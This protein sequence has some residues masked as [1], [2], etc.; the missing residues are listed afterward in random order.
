MKKIFILILMIMFVLFVVVCILK[1]KN[2]GVE[3]DF[4]EIYKEK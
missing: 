1:V 4:F 3:Y 2:D